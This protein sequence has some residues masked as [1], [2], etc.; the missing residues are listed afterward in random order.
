MSNKTIVITDDIDADSTGS[1]TTGEDAAS[2]DEGFNFRSTSGYVTDGADETYVTVTDIYP[3]TRGGVTFGLVTNLYWN[4]RDRNS[5]NDRRL[6]GLTFQDTA[7]ISADERAFR[8][9]LPAAG[10][11]TVH[12][13]AGDDS[14]AQHVAYVI[15]DNTSTLFTFSDTL[16]TGSGKF[17]DSL[18][19]E[20][21]NATWPGSHGTTSGLV[22]SSTIFR[23]ELSDLG[24]TARVITHIRIVRTA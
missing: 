4:H 2:F 3:T 21:T 5:S 24:T 15:K 19:G 14:G 22:F 1:A 7:G 18:G 12:I 23:L 16:T 9:D 13:A 20:Y 8:V 17:L 10:T 11:Y 6:A